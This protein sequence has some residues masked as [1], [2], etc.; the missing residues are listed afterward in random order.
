MSRMLLSRG[1]SVLVDIIWL[2]WVVVAFLIFLYTQTYIDIDQALALKAI[3]GFSLLIGGL[4]MSYML[5][6][7]R[8]DNFFSLSDF[9]NSLG[10]VFISIMA[11]YMVN[12]YG[13]SLQL[14]AVPIS[15][16]LFMILMAVAEEG[17]FRGFLTTLFIKMT[18]SSLIG[19]GLS[20]GI[21]LA[22]HAAV[23]G[24]SNTNMAITFGSFFVLGF[25]YVLSNYRISV[26]ITAHAL[27]NLIASMG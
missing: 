19:V 9:S 16:T 27:V 5:V 17:L 13:S 25:C 23:Y 6:G 20:S 1:K 7:F 21:G 2:F 14:S 26:P 15:G 3:V 24:S 12:I 18:G 10:Y 4:M 11:I 8:A 22:Y